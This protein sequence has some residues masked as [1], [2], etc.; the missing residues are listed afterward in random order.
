[1]IHFDFGE[2]LKYHESCLITSGKKKLS[3]KANNN[4]SLRNVKE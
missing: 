3:F 1:V 2:G 4:D